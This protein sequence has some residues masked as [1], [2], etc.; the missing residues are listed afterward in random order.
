M[1]GLNKISR[2][3]KLGLAKPFKRVGNFD[4]GKMHRSPVPTDVTTP[5]T[6]A[7]GL[8]SHLFTTYSK[9]KKKMC[10]LGEGGLV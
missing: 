2:W 6:Q 5:P 9:K 4:R 1:D 7:R 10:V 8:P 3:E